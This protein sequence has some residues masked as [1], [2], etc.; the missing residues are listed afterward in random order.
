MAPFQHIPHF[1]RRH[2]HQHIVDKYG[3]SVTRA[4]IIRDDWLRAHDDLKDMI[5]AVFFQRG[6]AVNLEA[7]YIFHSK[8]HVPDLDAYTTMHSMQGSLIPDLL[9]NNFLLD[10]K[11][12]HRQI[13]MY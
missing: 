7:P 9:L 1:I 5:G 3:E 12:L 11:M 8:A 13:Y 4:T 2:G 6:F 10:L